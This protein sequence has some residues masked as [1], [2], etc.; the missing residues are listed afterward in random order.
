[1]SADA[2]PSVTVGVNPPT[3]S[4]PGADAELG[5]F[6]GFFDLKAAGYDDPLLVAANDG[7]GTKLKLAIDL[8]REVLEVPKD[9]RIGI[10][11][12]FIA[13]ALY[14]LLPIVRNTHA[15]K[16]RGYAIVTISLKPIGGAPGATGRPGGIADQTRRGSK[17]F[18]DTSPG[19]RRHAGPG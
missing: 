3:T 6:G 9:Y 17:R 13:L 14:A 11:P 2:S 7:V 18:G 8:T 12:A 5:G 10:V 15:H 19:A 4:R 1:M 16:Q